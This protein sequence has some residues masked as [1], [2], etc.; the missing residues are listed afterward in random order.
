MYV[1]ILLFFSHFFKINSLFSVC[2]ILFCQSWQLLNCGT[3]G[4]GFGATYDDL[5]NSTD[6]WNLIIY[7][8][9]C[10][11][12]WCLVHRGWFALIKSDLLMVAVSILGILKI[13]SELAQFRVFTSCLFSVTVESLK[14]VRLVVSVC[15]RIHDFT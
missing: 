4:S 1:C 5:N 14:T 7:L 9:W 13:M 3:A 15:S 8:Y 6:K 11:W 12:E 2:F 10:Q